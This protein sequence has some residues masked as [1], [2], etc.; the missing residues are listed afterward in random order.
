MC[1]VYVYP[2]EPSESRQATNS[3]IGLKD[4]R[5]PGRGTKGRKQNVGEVRK[6]GFQSRTDW[7]QDPA[8]LLTRYMTSDRSLN[9]SLPQFPHLL[10]GIITVRRSVNAMSGPY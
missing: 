4:P 3:S 8:L 2:L 1:C 5:P 6:I 10:S 9:I 7:A